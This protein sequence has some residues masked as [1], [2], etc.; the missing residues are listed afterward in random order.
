MHS[1]LHFCLCAAKW[2]KPVQILYIPASCDSRIFSEPMNRKGRTE[3]RWFCPNAH[4]HHRLWLSGF[5]GVTKAAVL[6]L[7]V[8]NRIS[9]EVSHPSQM[10]LKQSLEQRENTHVTFKDWC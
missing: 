6:T 2:V 9:P 7:S 3:K 8:F 4:F 1:Y 5:C 10:C